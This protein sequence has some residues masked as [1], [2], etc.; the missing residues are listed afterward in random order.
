MY[1]KKLLAYVLIILFLGCSQPDLL[2]NENKKVY[3]DDLK[4]KWILINY[5]ADWCPPCIKEIPELN[6]LNSQF[7]DQVS[8]FLFNFDR[9]EGNELKKQLL[10]IKAE[11]PSLISD[12]QLIYNYDVPD[13]LPVTFVIDKD[14]KLSMTLKGPQTLEEMKEALNL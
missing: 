6:K 12:P 11:I 7:G 2:T 4:G 13:A 9:L 14:G 3:L 1:Y 8:V 5:W 10:K